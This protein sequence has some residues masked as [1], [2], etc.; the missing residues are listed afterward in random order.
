MNKQTALWVMVIG[1]ALSAYDY[2]TTPDGGTGG[3]LYGVG[4]PLESMRWSVYTKAATTAPAAP[5]KDYY[6]SVSD[7]AAL[8]GAF[9][10]FR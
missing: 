3:A 7:V 2:T 9:F 5:A 6:I 8:A 1:A 10:Y 4:K